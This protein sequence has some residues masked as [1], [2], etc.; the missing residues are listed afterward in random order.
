MQVERSDS[1]T[2]AVSTLNLCPLK[3]Q[4]HRRLPQRYSRLSQSFAVNLSS[5]IT[6]LKRRLTLHRRGRCD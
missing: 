3:E 2:L 5:K 6:E 1:E 4:I